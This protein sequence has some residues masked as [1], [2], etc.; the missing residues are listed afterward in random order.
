MAAM[1]GSESAWLFVLQRADMDF[2]A[3]K[4]IFG[5]RLTVSTPERRK[6]RP[7]QPVPFDSALADALLDWK[8]RC[9]YNQ[10]TDYIL[11]SG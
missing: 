1:T 11:A 2:G 9:P 8:A 6:L 7:Q 10:N 3:L 5:E 4:S